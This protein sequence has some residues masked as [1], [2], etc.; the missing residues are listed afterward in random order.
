MFRSL[1]TIIEYHGQAYNT[2]QLLPSYYAII[3][4]PKRAPKRPFG[5]NIM[6]LEYDTS[7][8]QSVQ[9]VKLCTCCWDIL[10]VD[11]LDLCIPLAC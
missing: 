1:G 5:E 9:L 10:Q 7:F 6:K 11:I 2:T 8:Q 3:A 4:Q